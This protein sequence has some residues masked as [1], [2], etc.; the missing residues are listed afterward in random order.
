MER[1]ISHNSFFKYIPLKPLITSYGRFLSY[2]N[3]NNILLTKK[4]R[5][6]AMLMYF[7]NVRPLLI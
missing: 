2:Y 5:K 6:Q 4:I 3:N 1:A 7:N